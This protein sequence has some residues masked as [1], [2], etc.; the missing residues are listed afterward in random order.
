[1][2]KDSTN[3]KFLNRTEKIK[4]TQIERKI[5]IE[6]VKQLN[7]A[8]I[9]E[10]GEM[11][12]H[13][14]GINIGGN[15]AQ[16]R[17]LETIDYIAE[18]EGFELSTAKKNL[19]IY[20]IKANSYYTIKEFDYKPVL[21]CKNGLYYF[22]GIV[23]TIEENGKAVKG[24]THFEYHSKP[25]I[26]PYKS[27]IQINAN[28]DPKAECLGID[29][30]L[31][32]VLGFETV[33]L[34]YEWLAYCCMNS[35]KYGK[36]LMLYGQTGTGKTSILNIIF[37]FLGTIN[38]SQIPLHRLSKRFQIAF[39]R[40]KLAN[41]FDDL[42]A[43]EI[44]YTDGFRRLCTNEYLS[45]EQKGKGW[46]D[47]L[48][49]CKPIFSCNELPKV[50]KEVPNAFY[51]RWILLP[52]F[53]DLEELGILDKT[54]RE[55][56]Y[57]EEELSGLLNKVIQYWNRLEEDQGF[58]GNWDNLDYVK[59]NWEIDINP[60]ALFVDEC[61]DLEVGEV[62]YELFHS[63]VNKFRRAHQVKE[64]SKTIMTKSLL[65]LN[66]KIEKKK[67]NKKY[68][69]ESSGHKFI[70]IQ[71]KPDFIS[72]NIKFEEKPTLVKYMNEE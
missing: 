66:N 3:N 6:I 63:Q 37:Q 62:D 25:R 43:K 10:F 20:F 27:F 72:E 68:H 14:E 7:I 48:N 15:Y 60:V 5:A 13:M 39:T 32:D 49:R 58:I 12:I 23:G 36:A 2:S 28:Y 33:P 41:L 19:I 9:R 38:I 70:G 24:I 35:V 47:W 1:M 57:S 30:V 69:P 53:N 31:T 56:K 54:I 22:E 61:C 59:K 4:E 55:K 26:E 52:C 46:I 29:Q 71:F 40:N 67:V 45:G 18:K 64:I 44:D 16:S 21:N 8:T 17:I 42:P 34:F 50:K 11:T 51:N 65:K